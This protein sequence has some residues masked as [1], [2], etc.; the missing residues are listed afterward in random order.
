M[1][2]NGGILLFVAAAAAAGMAMALANPLACSTRVTAHK[3]NNANTSLLYCLQRKWTLLEMC[4]YGCNAAG[5]PISL[6]PIMV[7]YRS[8]AHVVVLSSRIACMQCLAIACFLF[9]YDPQCEVPTREQSGMCV[10]T[11]Q[12]DRPSD[13][14]SKHVPRRRSVQVHAQAVAAH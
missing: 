13:P 5:K 7:L 2:R 10:R 11:V 9:E 4:L 14:G 3:C 1:P 8:T 12:L 6:P